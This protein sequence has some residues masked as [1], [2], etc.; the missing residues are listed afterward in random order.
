[1]TKFLTGH[2]LP[3]RPSVGGWVSYG[4][5][6]ENRNLPS[7][8]VLITKGKGGQPL[9]AHLWGSGF[10]PARH[11]GVLFRA[12]KDPVLYLGNPAGV[13]AESRRRMLDRLAE[14]NRLQQEDL[15]DPEINSRVAQYEMAYRMQES[16][17]DLMD[18]T[19]ESPATLERYGAEPGKPTYANACLLAR[20]LVE[21]G[22][23]FVQIFHE[24]WDQH[25]NLPRD[26]T[27]Q[28]HDVD[29]ACYGL[30]TDLKQR[31]LLDDTLVVWTGEFGRT[32]KINKNAGRDHWGPCFTVLMGGGGVQGGRVI[33]AS[34]KWAAQPAH[35]PYGPEDMAATLYHLLGLDPLDE[36][37]TPEGRPIMIANNGRVMKELL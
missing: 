1:M 8:V 2:Q 36:M 13:S 10:L 12:A 29:Q 4:L 27:S 16:A 21:R 37:H 35:T 5:G 33:G 20:R 23:R 22:V 30:I 17:P 31:G 11:Q 14:M 25:G 24:A 7:F 32:P 19:K 28:C 26:H 6:T 18:L 3:G 34:D 9:G 15:G